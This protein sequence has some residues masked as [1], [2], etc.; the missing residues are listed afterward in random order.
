MIPNAIPFYY[1]RRM[2]NVLLA[3]S[4]E[5]VRKMHAE[6]PWCRN[7]SPDLARK[8]ATHLLKQSKAKQA[9]L[10]AAKRD[11]EP[12]KYLQVREIRQTVRGCGEVPAGRGGED[13]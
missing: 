3:D 2:K 1:F 8:I 9:E 5:E 6:K 11:G 7:S 4:P 13:H 10:K 12:K